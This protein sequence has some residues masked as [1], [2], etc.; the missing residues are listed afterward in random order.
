MDILTN[1][2]IVS[3]TLLC[4]LCLCRINVLLAIMISAIVAGLT[5]H[6]SIVDIMDVFVSGMGG[7]SDTALSYI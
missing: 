5:A 4:L 3:V 6:M 7:N 2:I 1:P